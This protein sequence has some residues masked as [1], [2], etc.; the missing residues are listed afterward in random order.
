[1]NTQT[2]QSPTVEMDGNKG[3][4]YCGGAASHFLTATDSNRHTS[5]AEFHCY[6]CPQCGLIFMDSAPHD[7]SP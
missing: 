6:E 3:C 4:P 2:A 7:M 1:V 5:D